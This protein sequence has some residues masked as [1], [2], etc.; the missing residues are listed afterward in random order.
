MS[1]QEPAVCGAQTYLPTALVPVAIQF[2]QTAGWAD[3][4]DVSRH[5]RCTLQAHPE[6]DHYAIVM[7]LRGLQAGAVWTHW[8]AGHF[9]RELGVL[10]NCARGSLADPCTSFEEHPGRCYPDL[11]DPW[12]AMVRSYPPLI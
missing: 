11:H 12:A 1:P 10:L 4:S 9:P 6:G 2:E 8:A 5:L 7:E 3:E